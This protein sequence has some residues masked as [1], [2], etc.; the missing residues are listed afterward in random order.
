[1]KK[2]GASQNNSNDR[3]SKSLARTSKK[4]QCNSDG[5]KK[6]GGQNMKYN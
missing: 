6:K 5:D 1:V 2:I 3:T 4:G